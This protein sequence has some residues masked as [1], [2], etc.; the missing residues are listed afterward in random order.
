MLFVTEILV[1]VVLETLGNLCEHAGFRVQRLV[2]IS[3]DLIQIDLVRWIP[4][5]KWTSLVAT[6]LVF[7]GLDVAANKKLKS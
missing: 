7:A 4:P 3:Y 1:F 2:R 5:H 6:R